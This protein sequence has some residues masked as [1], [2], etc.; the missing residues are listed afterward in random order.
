VELP[1]GATFADHGD[2]Q[3]NADEGSAEFALA[4]AAQAFKKLTTSNDDDSY[5]LYHAPKR[6][7]AVR[8][9]RAGVQPFEEREQEAVEGPGTI[10]GSG[11]TITGVATAFRFFFTPGDRIVFNG[12]T[13]VVTKVDGDLSLVVSSPFKP[14]PDGEKYQRLGTDRERA[15][16]YGFVGRPGPRAGSGDT[17]M[18]IAGDV[19]AILCLGGA[20]RMLIDPGKE[21]AVADLTNVVD[22]AGG[23][24]VPLQK[25]EP[26]NRVFRNWC[27][28]RRLV[29]EW[30][31]VVLGGATP[32]AATAADANPGGRVLLQ[33]GW[34]QAL[35]KWMRV[36]DVHGQSAVDGARRDAGGPNEPTNLELSQAIA[37]LLDMPAPVAVRKGP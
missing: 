34:V 30:R 26:I 35:R 19:A 20:S 23:A 1:P 7:Q 2:V 13:R 4:T 3:E 36:V 29:D 32:D 12:Q 8:F 15:S 22:V 17:I 21:E 31:E 37:R 14:A 5:V 6:A 25:L 18:E 27:L 28:D 24:A 16:G 10:S 9:D 11:T 33:Q